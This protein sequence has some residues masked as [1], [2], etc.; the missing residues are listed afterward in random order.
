MDVILDVFDMLSMA[1][2]YFPGPVIFGFILFL[3]VG[4][5]RIII[6]LL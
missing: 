1:M 6:D 4:V 2:V 3:F 5:I